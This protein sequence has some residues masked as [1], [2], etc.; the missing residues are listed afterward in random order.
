M[1]VK[2]FYNSELALTVCAG[3]FAI[4]AT[5]NALA[6]PLASP[7]DNSTTL[8]SVENSLSLAGN[9]A[10][11]GTQI[12]HTSLFM[13]P[14]PQL[15]GAAR[16][17]TITDVLGRAFT[18]DDLN[19]LYGAGGFASCETSSRIPSFFEKNYSNFA[20]GCIEDFRSRQA[21][22]F[23]ERF[24][25]NPDS[26]GI[27]ASPLGGR[28]QW[29]TSALVRVS[30]CCSVPST[31]WRRKTKPCLTFFKEESHSILDLEGFFLAEIQALPR[32]KHRVRIT[33]LR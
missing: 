14:P 6:V 29:N 9:D 2:T 7:N 26:Q 4:A 24:Q 33:W 27:A 28:V 10:R 16:T 5:P 22:N 31:I 15:P 19:S 18:R 32:V 20:A 1:T 25:A 8:S 12:Q 13:T 3:V 17:P 11:N 21:I 23:D 30:V